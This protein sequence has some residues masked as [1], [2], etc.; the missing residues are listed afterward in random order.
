MAENGYA[1]HR[2]RGNDFELVS[3]ALHGSRPLSPDIDVVEDRCYFSLLEDIWDCPGSKKDYHAVKHH[4]VKFSPEHLSKWDLDVS[5]LPGAYPTWTCRPFW[6]PR[7]P[8]LLKASNVLEWL[9]STDHD[10]GSSHW[11]DF[12]AH[13]FDSVTEQV[14]D[15]VDIWNLGRDIFTLKGLARQVGH[16]LDKLWALLKAAGAFAKR[17]FVQTLTLR[18]LVKNIADAYLLNEFGIKPV[19]REV[20]SLAT[21]TVSIMKRLDFL[22]RTQGSVFTARYA[23]SFPYTK[24]DETL[25]LADAYGFSNSV[26]RLTDVEGLVKYTCTAKVKNELFGLDDTLA[27]LAGYLHA[28]R[29][30][31]IATFVWDLVPFSFVVDWFAN[32]SGLLDRYVSLNA[33]QG[34]L[35]VISAGTGFKKVCSGN[36]VIHGSALPDGDILYGRLY[37]KQY[38]RRTGIER[39]MDFFSSPTDLTPKQLDV[40]SALITQRVTRFSNS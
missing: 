39:G 6:V 29:V 7:T 27:A 9:D 18:Q 8:Y 20:V 15:V 31:R 23:E 10:I 22:R 28:F 1:R 5:G 17:H 4:V 14:P 25:D 32:I 26:I 3:V 2:R 21:K 19:I 40:L 16:L 11:K 33:F 36:L 37:L 35:K 24:G 34:E 13:A 30:D 12:L 38:E